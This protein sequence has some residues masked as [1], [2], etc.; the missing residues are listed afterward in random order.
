VNKDMQLILG[1][2]A[3]AVVFT[4]LLGALVLQAIRRQSLLLSIV[5]A[6][7]VPMAAVSAAVALSVNRMVISHHD[8]AVVTVALGFST[9]LAVALS[10]VLGRRVASG[11]RDL[12]HALRGLAE[13]PYAEK[14]TLAGNGR[15]SSPA[16]I[17]AL[18]TELE[19]TREKLRLSRE[20]ERSLEQSRRELVTFMSHDPKPAKRST[21]PE[22]S[23]TPPPRVA[24]SAVGGK[25]IDLCAKYPD[26]ALPC[27]GTSSQ[28][29]TTTGLT[30]GLAMTAQMTSPSGG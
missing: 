28:A 24:M 6:A 17:T 2:T 21:A 19:M 12:T 1:L 22:S 9:V 30:D 8:S 15:S 18:A 25:D 13:G 29:R 27:E 3:G 20:R 26:S 4:G 11:S 23:R 10:F 7:V 14:S 16:E 5:V